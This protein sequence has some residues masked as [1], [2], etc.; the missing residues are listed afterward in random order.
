MLLV[1]LYACQSWGRGSEN[2][3]SLS[4]P[5]IVGAVVPSPLSYAYGNKQ[6]T[7]FLIIICIERQTNQ[8]TFEGEEKTI[9]GLD[10]RDAHLPNLI[11][12]KPDLFVKV[13]KV[14]FRVH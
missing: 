13:T 7:Q 12:C 2:P 8:F 4:P 11:L 1:G 5:S 6:V 9:D 10:L 3:L 14:C